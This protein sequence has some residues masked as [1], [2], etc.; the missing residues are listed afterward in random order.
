MDPIDIHTYIYKGKS[1]SLISYTSR[2]YFLYKISGVKGFNK[3]LFIMIQKI[4]E[5]F[6][7]YDDGI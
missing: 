5:C 3:S 7:I 4:I 6:D 1:N 2:Y